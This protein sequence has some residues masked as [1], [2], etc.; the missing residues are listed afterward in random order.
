MARDCATLKYPWSQNTSQKRARAPFGDLLAVGAHPR[1][2]VGRQR[3]RSQECDLDA[4]QVVTLA[5]ASQEP[6]AFEL[7]LTLQVVSGLRLDCRRAT[8]KP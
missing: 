3:V 7:A 8:F 5:E 6:R 4:R 2:S 1:A